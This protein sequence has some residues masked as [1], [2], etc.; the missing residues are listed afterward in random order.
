MSS[1]TFCNQI[2]VFEQGQITE[3]GTHEALMQKEGTYAKLFEMQSQ[4]YVE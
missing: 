1:A 3:Y 2:A 4:F